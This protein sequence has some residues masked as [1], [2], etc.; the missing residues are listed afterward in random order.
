MSLLAVGS[1]RQSPSPTDERDALDVET[2]QL[3][4]L[5]A[6]PRVSALPITLAS[7]RPD[8]ASRNAEAWTVRDA[9]GGAERIALYT[10]SEVFSCAKKQPRSRQCLVKLA[11]IITHEAWHF[12]NGPNEAG[13]YEV[14]LAFLRLPRGAA[15]DSHGRSP[16]A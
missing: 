16:C 6:G 9:S 2:L 14:R 11:S 3:A 1:T 4:L 15:R 10:K 8:S 5:L 13:A 12:R 7:V